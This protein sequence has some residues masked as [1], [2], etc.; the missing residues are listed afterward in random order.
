MLNDYCLYTLS[1]NS[2]LDQS[3]QQDSDNNLYVTNIPF[4]HAIH[5][6]TQMHNT[7][8]P[9]VLILAAMPSLDCPRMVMDTLYSWV[10]LPRVLSLA[11]MPSLDCPW[12]V[13]DT[14]YSWVTLPGVLEPGYYAILGLS[15]NGRGYIVF[16]SYFARGSWAWLLCHPWT[17]HGWSW[18]H[19][20]PELLCQGILSLAAMPSLDYPWMVVDTLYSW[21]TLPGV[22]EPGCYAILGLSMDGRRYIVF[23]SYFARGSWAWLL[24]HPWTIHGW[25]WI[26]CIPELL[27]QGILSLAA[28]PSLDYP[29]MVVDT[30]YSWV[31]LPGVLEPGCYAILGLSMD[32]RG[33]IV[34]LSYFARGSWAWLLCH[35]WTV[36]EWSWIHCIP[37]LLCQGFLSLAAMP[38]LDCP[39]MVV[40]TLYSWVTLPGDLE[41]GYYAILGLSMNGRGYIVFLSYFARGSWAWLL[42]HPWTVHGWSWIHCI[43]ELLCQGFLSLAAMPSLDYP[44]MVVDTLFSWV[45]L[46]GVLE[47]GCYAILGLSMDGRRYI[48]FLSYFARGS[49]AWL[50]C[51]LWTVHGWSWIHC[52]PEL[53]CQGILSLAA[54]P[55]LDCPWMVVDT[56][57]SW[58][59][60]P[61]GL[62]PGYYAIL[63]LSINWHECNSFFDIQWT[64]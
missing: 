46:P 18:I 59:T 36:H 21:V 60:L 40:D 3:N 57:Y 1:N 53:L 47:P 51:H 13:V 4:Y 39:W 58:V 35:P 9:E 49:W 19:C 43:P 17:V 48:V 8:L 33:Y 55:S 56:L 52:I 22:L 6:W 20:I 31:T 23:L 11:A 15:M 16:L 5:A 25:S 27:C 14:L 29:W 10:T 24:C 26:H 42:C 38:S 41:P 32:G 2:L 62:E 7:G 34:F 12:M 37:E 28:M 54:M 61:G 44:W 30:L 63:G 64:P 45:T 50:L